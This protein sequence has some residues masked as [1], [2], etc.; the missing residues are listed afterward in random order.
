MPRPPLALALLLVLLCLFP[1]AGAAKTRSALGPGQTL[2]PGQALVAGSS[3]LTLQRNGDLALS[4]VPLRAGTPLARRAKA[5]GPE[6][7]T[8]RCRFLRPRRLWHT[9][10]AGHPGARLRVRAD[11]AAVLSAG[12][13]TLWSSRTHHPGASL[14]LSTDG[15]LGVYAPRGARLSTTGPE[16]EAELEVVWQTGTESP[17]YAGSELGP[18][19][20]LEPG[21]YLQSPNGQYEL[22]MTPSGWMALWVRGAGPCPM[23]IA[24]ES[25]NG[26]GGERQPGSSLAMEAN[27]VL[28]LRPPASGDAPLW[29]MH[30]YDN[31]HERAQPTPIAGS[32]LVLE[33]D[34]NFAVF[35]PDGETVWQTETERI[36]GPVLCPG[37]SLWYG[38]LLG[39]VYSGPGSS[40]QASYYLQLASANRGRGSEL[41]IVG[42]SRLSVTHLYRDKTGPSAEGMYVQMQNW[43][44]LQVLLDG[45]DGVPNWE[46]GTTFPNSFATVTYLGSL[47]IYAPLPNAEGKRVFR[48]IYEQPDVDEELA[49]G[50]G[51]AEKI[52]MSFA[53]MG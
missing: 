35:A 34:G 20:V 8:R 52:S 24:P 3:R 40:Y 5:P 47:Q 1:A 2:A 15:N 30:N 36:R 39:S 42:A 29:V 11:G 28:A 53:P 13:R 46:V 18:G 41:D 16:F 6:C 45:G 50:I 9:D 14:R 26:T 32:R 27:G 17:Q 19:E 23:F 33:N 44:D 10:S 25:G 48:L 4:Y 22:D 51:Q 12:G 49:A 37:E 38:Q 31:P 43:G 21:Q 7:R